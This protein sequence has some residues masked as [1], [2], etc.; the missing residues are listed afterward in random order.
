MNGDRFTFASVAGAGDT[1][2]GRQGDEP[3]VCRWSLYRGAEKAWALKSAPSEED[4]TLVSEQ[5][6]SIL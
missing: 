1:P 3:I 2:L 6:E 4:E 5:P